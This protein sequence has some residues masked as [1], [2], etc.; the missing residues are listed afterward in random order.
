LFRIR[1]AYRGYQATRYE[2][3]GRVLPSII[4]DAEALG[5]VTGP[6]H[7]AASEARCLA[8]DAVAA[9]LSRVGEKT[10]AWTAADRA[11]SAAEQ[12]GQPILTALI[13]YRLAYVLANRKYPGEAVQLSMTAASALER[14]MKSPT[15][16]LLN[17]YGG[18]YLAAAS[19]AATGYDRSITPRFLQTAHVTAERL[20]RNAN[21]M[22]TGFGP[23]NIAIHTMATSI[24]L[25]DA[26]SAIE[27]GESLDPGALPLR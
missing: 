20:G 22:G 25:G 21:L 18:L 7:P 17:V 23:V 5:R 1:S 4:R 16:D 6:G 24:R 13:S 2:E 9:L 19:A 15:P 26:R 12:S 14:T 8:Y 3:T 27:V 10:L 11:M